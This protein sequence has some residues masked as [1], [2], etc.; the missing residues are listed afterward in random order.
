LPSVFSSAYPTS[1]YLLPVD[2]CPVLLSYWISINMKY[3]IFK[4]NIFGEVTTH[5]LRK[6][7]GIGWIC[8]IL[9]RI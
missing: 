8:A 4:I 9:C 3:V 5:E 6:A 7:G 1:S 2:I